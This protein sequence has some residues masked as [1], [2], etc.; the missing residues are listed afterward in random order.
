M[1]VNPYTLAHLCDKGI[2]NQADIAMLNT[3]TMPLVPMGNQYLNMAMGGNLYQN[4]GMAY[5]TFHSC[6]AP[7]SQ[8]LYPN[9]TTSGGYNGIP[10]EIGSLSNTGGFN[11]FNGYGTGL[12]NQ[13]NL[14]KGFGED[15]ITGSKAGI[16]GFSAFKGCDNT[17]NNLSNNFNKTASVLGKI[18]KEVWGV[19]AGTIGIIGIILALKKRKTVEISVEKSGFLSKLKSWIKK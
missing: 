1:A 14:I 6:Y 9:A 19:F 3:S 7:T 5:D 12:Y 10:A 11:A 18:P 13:N 16:Q 8:P 4:Y 17:Q 2:L 15:G